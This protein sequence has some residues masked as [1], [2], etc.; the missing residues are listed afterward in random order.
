VPVRPSIGMDGHRYSSLRYSGARRAAH[1][2]KESAPG[3][4]MDLER[5]V[6]KSPFSVVAPAIAPVACRR[7][8]GPFCTRPAPGQRA[9]SFRSAGNSPKRRVPRGPEIKHPHCEA[10]TGTS[11]CIPTPTSY[12]PMDFTGKPMKSMIYVCATGTD[13][14]KA[15]AAW[16]ESAVRL[17]RGLPGKKEARRAGTERRITS[18][19]LA[20]RG[21][22]ISRSASKRAARKRG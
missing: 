9:C 12:R 16:V 2:R 5:G 6:V 3:E 19:G 1:E 18:S 21:S 10:H 17:A 4:E 15:L 13:S 8:R 22:A 7:T 11:R 20:A 14:E